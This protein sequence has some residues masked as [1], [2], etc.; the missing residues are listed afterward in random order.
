RK[1]LALRL[2]L[3][4]TKRVVHPPL[5]FEVVLHDAPTVCS[6]NVGSGGRADGRRTSRRTAW[7]WSVHRGCGRDVVRDADH[8]WVVGHRPGV[9]EV[10]GQRRRA[11]VDGA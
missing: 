7:W 4:V 5:L 2:K 8:A 6:T 9:R 1:F 3:R 11:D 10:E